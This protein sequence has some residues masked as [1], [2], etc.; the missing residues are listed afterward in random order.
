MKYYYLLLNGSVAITLLVLGIVTIVNDK[1]S[2]LNRLFFAFAVSVG[3]WIVSAYVSND[4]S[5]ANAVSLYGNYLVFAFSY[6][7]SYFFLWLTIYIVKN[8]RAAHLLRRL[9]IPIILVGLASA[10]PMVVSG[11]GVQ[12]NV[13]A[14]Y[15][16]PLILLYAVLLLGQLI[17]SLVVLRGGIKQ[18]NGEQ[19]VRMKVIFRSMVVALPVLVVTQFIAP[20]VTGSFEITDIGI[21]AMVLPVAG[22]YYSTIKHG[23][24]DIRLAAVRSSTYILSLAALSGIY[25]FVA[26]LISTV[27]FRE[28][29][30]SSLSVGPLNI[31]LALILAFAFQP[32]RHFFDKATNSI[33]YRDNYDSDSFFARVN[34]LLT[35][36]TDLR[37]LLQ[38]LAREVGD[39]LKADRA[40]FFVYHTEG[41]YVSVGAKAQTSLS[42]K[43]ARHL[44]TYIEIQGQGL[45]I[46]DLLPEGHAIRRLLLERGVTMLLPLM[47][48]STVVGYLALGDQKNGHYTERDVKVLSTISDG[49]VVAIQNS[50][51]VQEIKDINAHLQQK[52]DA[53][54]EELRTSNTQLRRLDAAK[55]EFVSM[56]SHQLRT[57][58]TSVKGYISMVLEGDA[59][60]ISDMQRQ[61]LGEAFTSSERMVHLINDFLNVSRLQTGKFMVDRRSIDLAKVINQ[62]VDS[63]Q[64]TAHAHD[65]KLQYRPPSR[66]PVLYLDEGKI[67]QVVMNFIDNAI[68]YSREFTTITVKLGVVDGN[69]EL[70]VSDTGMGVPLAEQKHLFTKFFRATNARKQ[71]PDGTGVGL[72]LAKKVIVAHGG[73]MI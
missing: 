49:L 40:S 43:D 8:L 27:I 21:L 67:R 28:Q 5:N 45:I 63:L 24:F 69:V 62:E 54:T 53:A 30:N 1:K 20:A 37:T 15:F 2:L 58:L 7:S 48:S 25:Y 65:L 31:F 32:I 66:L 33:F 56:A 39:T 29:G 71:R 14:V 19:Q 70:T 52:I 60:K 13:Y 22:L 9:S 11:V 46:V 17:A 35:S 55:D 47:Q 6:F 61:L 38:R 42:L 16:G 12:G 34:K 4:T 73:S 50:L 3:I 59:G 57:P 72:F 44:D 68:Y 36:T 41:R 64:T 18:S 26:Y 51:S 10:S 23:L